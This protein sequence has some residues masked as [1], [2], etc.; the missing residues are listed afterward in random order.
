MR[1][2]KRQKAPS[3]AMNRTDE[4]R[5]LAVEAQDRGDTERVVHYNRLVQ[6]VLHSEGREQELLRFRLREIVAQEMWA[7][8]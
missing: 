1:P 5:K 8:H 7:K 3:E 2:D 6:A 4:F